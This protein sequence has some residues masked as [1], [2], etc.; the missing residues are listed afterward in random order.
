VVGE[1]A[2]FGSADRNLYGVNINDGAEVWK[3][4]AGQRFSASPAVGE[5]RLVIG[6]DQSGGKI[7]CFGAK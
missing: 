7:Y 4:N 6:A 1:R 5:G 2:F 3:F